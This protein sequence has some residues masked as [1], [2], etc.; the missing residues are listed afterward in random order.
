MSPFR[1]NSTGTGVAVVA[2]HDAS[3]VAAPV[4]QLKVHCECANSQSEQ[5]WQLLFKHV[6]K[7]DS[8]HN[9]LV[10]SQPSTHDLE[11]KLQLDGDTH[12]TEVIL[13]GLH[14]PA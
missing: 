9:Q 8:L 10:L 3:L 6:A 12:T 14:V 7:H 13:Y 4:W 1:E 5:V 11:L 2:R